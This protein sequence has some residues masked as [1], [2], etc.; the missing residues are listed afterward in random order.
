MVSPFWLEDS[1]F[2][3]SVS[4]SLDN[5][6]TFLLIMESSSLIM[7]CAHGQHGISF[8]NSFYPSQFLLIKP[9]S[10]SLAYGLYLFGFWND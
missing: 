6:S 7:D 1:L 3:L 10:S 9:H 2:L 4:F 8:V 5:I